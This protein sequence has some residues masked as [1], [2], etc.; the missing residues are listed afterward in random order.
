M[1]GIDIN[2][3][4]H[5]KQNGNVPDEVMPAKNFTVKE[6]SKMF[7]DTENTKD[8]MVEADP[9]LDSSMTV[10]QGIRK[11]CPPYLVIQLDGGKHCSNYS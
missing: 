5:D 1:I 3:V 7:H 4:V 9:N 8:E 6:L 11:M 10:H 2:E